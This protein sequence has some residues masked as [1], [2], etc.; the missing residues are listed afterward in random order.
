MAARQLRVHAPQNALLG[1][2]CD[3]GGRCVCVWVRAGVCVR[4]AVGEHLRSTSSSENRGRTLPSS[5]PPSPAV[6][7]S[8]S[9]VSPGPGRS[10]AN[11]HQHAWRTRRGGGRRRRRRR[12]VE[13][14][15]SARG[16]SSV[17]RSADV[18]F[19]QHQRKKERART[20]RCVAF[21]TSERN[22][23]CVCKSVRMRARARVE[24]T[25]ARVC[26]VVLQVRKAV[27]RVHQ[28]LVG[29]PSCQRRRWVAG[30]R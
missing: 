9:I 12:R 16:V 30:R 7:P 15:A 24:H 2:S 29:F 23:A 20:H 21:N 5:G 22:S 1:A 27:W 3:A 10:K 8:K 14:S 6:S 18:A 26:K 11:A 28:R 19:R 4:R 17:S 25:H 13:Y